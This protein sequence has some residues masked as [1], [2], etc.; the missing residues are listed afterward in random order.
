LFHRYGSP[1]QLGLKRKCLFHF[2]EKRKEAKRTQF[3]KISFRFCF[4][5]N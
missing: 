3:C 1:R 5:E 4:R 2:R